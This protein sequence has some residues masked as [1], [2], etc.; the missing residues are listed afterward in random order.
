[1]IYPIYHLFCNR[2]YKS[3]KAIDSFLCKIIKRGR[4][5]DE[6][7]DK[8]G[9]VYILLDDIEYILKHCDKSIR[10]CC[11]CEYINSLTHKNG[12][13]WEECDCVMPSRKIAYKF[14]K[15]LQKE[16]TVKRKRKDTNT[17]QYITNK[18]ENYIAINHLD[19]TKG[20]NHE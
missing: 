1:M 4:L 3:N 19:N 18:I 16:I 17:E 12:Y 15:W 14:Q 2:M 11:E 6:K 5:I 8:N 20:I 7:I 9:K 13:L 10:F